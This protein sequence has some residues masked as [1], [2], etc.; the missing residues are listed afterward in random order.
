MGLKHGRCLNIVVFVTEIRPVIEWLADHTLR[1]PTRGRSEGY[2]RRLSRRW[3]KLSTTTYLKVVEEYGHSR[4][5][6]TIRGQSKNTETTE[7][8]TAPRHITLSFARRVDIQSERTNQN[9]QRNQS[10]IYNVLNG[11]WWNCSTWLG[12]VWRMLA[13]RLSHSRLYF[14]TGNC[15]TIVLGGQSITWVKTVKALASGMARGGVVILT[16]WGLPDPPMQRL[17]TISDM[18]HYR[19]QCSCIRNLSPS[20]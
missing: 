1:R 13:E 3:V 12:P 10:S 5:Q 15:L 2:G 19:C 8:A 20:I 17:E 7:T 9:S 6:Y 16:V 18:T 11:K 4:Q 14:D